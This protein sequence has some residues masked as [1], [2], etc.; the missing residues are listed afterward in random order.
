MAVVVNVVVN[1]VVHSW[2]SF[3][4]LW[5]QDLLR[6]EFQRLSQRKMS[7]ICANSDIENKSSDHNDGG[8]T[9][10]DDNEDDDD[11]DVDEREH[12]HET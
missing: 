9:E 12:K 10:D 1:V 5:W 11:D 4:D 2:F 7:T 6:F 3:M 8:N